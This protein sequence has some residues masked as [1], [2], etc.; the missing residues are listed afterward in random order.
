MQR[1]GRT[2]GS[3]AKRRKRTQEAPMP[4]F[5]L[6]LA[7]ACGLVLAA[8]PAARAQTPVPRLE[9]HPCPVPSTGTATPAP[10]AAG[11]PSGLACASVAVP[12]DYAD[13]AGPQ[14][15]VGLARLPARHPEQR[16]GSLVFNPGG[17]GGSGGAFVV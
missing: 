9:W 4:R 7:V 1:A 10:A 12:L 5:V 8:V 3:R 15:T 2:T 6:G 11:A 16:I 17:P 13:P 14:I